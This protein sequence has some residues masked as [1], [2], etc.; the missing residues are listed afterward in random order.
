MW[1]Y[2]YILELSNGKHYVGCTADLKKRIARHNSGNVPSTKSYTPVK[3]IWSCA[4]PDRYKAYAFEKYMKSGSGR[5]FAQK[6][7]I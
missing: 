1:Y 5:A 6:H 4:F 2:V 7:L 3:L